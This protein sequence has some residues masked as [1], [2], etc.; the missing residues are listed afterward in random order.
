MTAAIAGTIRQRGDGTWEARFIAGK[1]PGTGKP[2]RKSV[3]AKTEKE[4][5]KKRAA[6]IAVLDRGDYK[7]P[8]KMTVAQWLD[9][10]QQEYLGGVKPYT[11]VSYTQHIENHIKPAMGAVKLDMLDTHTI[12]G[13][14]NRLRKPKGD[15]PG[16]S[17][18]TVKN[19]HGVLHSALQ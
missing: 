18:K 8:S 5:L 4:V 9:I 12:Q 2:I 1:N 15:K 3:Y 7:E 13:F 17:P 6:A 10:W 16:L 11:V 14:Y 19:I